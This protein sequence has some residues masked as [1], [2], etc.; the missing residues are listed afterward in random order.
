MITIPDLE[1]LWKWPRMVNPYLPDVEQESVAWSAKFGAF[2]PEVHALVHEKGKLSKSIPS[3]K[4][5]HPLSA[6]RCPQGP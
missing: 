2:S 4:V 1:V 5:V 6:L 3:L